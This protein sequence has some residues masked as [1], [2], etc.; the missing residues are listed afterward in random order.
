MLNEQTKTKLHAMRLSGMADAYEEQRT[1]SRMTELSFDERFGLL[2]ERQWL[3]KENRSLATRLAYAQLKEHACVEDLDYGD[4]RGLKRSAIEQ[5]VRGDWITYHQNVLIA[6]P[7]G[8][9]KTFLACALAQKVCR[10][11]FRAAYFYGPKLFRQLSLAHGDG[12]LTRLLKKIAK[13]QLL[14][15][16]DWGLGKLDD[17]QHRDFL[18]ILDDRHGNASTLITSQ[19]PVQDWHQSMPDPTIA[20]AILDRLI[21]NAHRVDLKGESMRKRKSKTQEPL[22]PSR[23]SQKG[24]I[25]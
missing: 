12:S 2:V 25:K 10:D 9:G 13:A 19:V 18:E 17:Q 3:W 14:V 16:D 5:L 23:E 24:P 1:A 8:T 4:G 21:H 15:I 11:G 7:T 6:G 20:D 22:P